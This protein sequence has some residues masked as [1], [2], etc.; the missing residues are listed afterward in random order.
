MGAPGVH[1]C[2]TF[3]QRAGRRTLRCPA[4]SVICSPWAVHNVQLNV[5]TS[6]SEFCALLLALTLEMHG[7]GQASLP[8]EWHLRVSFGQPV[9]PCIF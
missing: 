3:D 4:L 5:L 2:L 8:P 9:L 6:K 1:L 7:H